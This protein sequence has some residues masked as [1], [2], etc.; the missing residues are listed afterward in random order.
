MLAR[1]AQEEARAKR[2]R[3][4]LFFGAA[5]GVGKTYAMLEA[6]QARRRRGERVLVG[7]L[8][9]HGRAETEALARGLDHVPPRVVEY[10]GLSLREMDLDAVLARAPSLVLVDELAHTNAPSSRHERRWQDVEEILDAGIDVFTTLNVQHV[11]SLR[12]VVAQVTGVTVR[13]TV[14]DRILARA[15]EIELVDLPPDELLQRLREGKVYVPAQ[16]QQAMTSFFQKGNLL[17][18]RELALRRT[19]ERVDVQAEEW[20]RAQGV[21]R[22]WGARERI[23]VAVSPAPQAA[24]LVRAAARMAEGLKAPWIVLSVETPGFDLLPEADRARVRAHVALAESLG[25]EP[26]VVRGEKVGE[27][28][29]AAARARDVTR[30][31]VGK[32]APRG[33]LSRLRPTLV[34]YLVRRSGSMDVHVTTGVPGDRLEVPAVPS[35]APSARFGPAWA[36]AVVAVATGVGLATRPWATL[37][38]QSMIYL[39]AILATAARLSRRDAVIASIASVAAL[40]FFF[41]PPYLTFAVS[42]VRHAFTFAV[43]L[44][45]G[46]VVSG[47]AARVRAQAAAA[48][49]R[50]RRTGAFYALSRA[51][52]AESEPNGIAVLAARQA[53]EALGVGAVVFR[54]RPDGTVVAEAGGDAAIAS[55]ERERA[56]ARWVLS[57]RRPAGR[58]TSTLPGSEGLYL[59]LA[60]A[61]GVHGVLGVEVAKRDR[62]LTASEHQSLETVAALTAV[63]LERADLAGQAQRARIAVE[64]ERTRSTLLAAVSHDLRTPLASIVGAA[65]A[66]LE[67]SSGLTEEARRDLAASIRDEASRLGR[68]VADLLDLTRIEAGGFV[69]QREWFPLEEAIVSALDRTRPQLAG[70]EVTMSLP[71]D[72]LLVRVDGVL[73]EQVV[74]NLLENAARHTPAGTPVEIRVRTEPREVVLEVRDRGPGIPPAERER[75]FDRFHRLPTAGGSE[76][77]GLGLALCRAIVRAHGGHIEVDERP[78]GG[79]VFR[80]TLPRDDQA[81]PA[82]P[83]E[84]PVAEPAAPPAAPSDVREAT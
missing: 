45:A 50:E 74:V 58:T 40:D 63:A 46:L 17:A 43:L 54:E 61:G 66:L 25:A 57:N 80:V 34:D 39:L 73:V 71:S 36:L 81:E 15:D 55:S 69:L 26:L 21:R 29:L 5:P 77:A 1:A 10:R 8:E 47:Y 56:V 53:R 78:G 13:E 72:V 31:V 27:E 9:T 41:V 67:P 18:L 35:P 19:A 49:E 75:V 24:D 51:F 65:G 48:R 30:L 7:W 79:A 11:E 16:A 64:T 2:G 14:P 20:R 44:A 37:A 62:P 38:D 84:P 70:R 22:P 33:F 52:S 60:T 23:L 32:P 4:K 76:G 6:A 28:I 42:D 82:P 12:D 83:A 59:P 68:L 3:L